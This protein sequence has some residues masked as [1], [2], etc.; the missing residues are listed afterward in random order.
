[1]RGESLGKTIMT[2]RNAR[3][4]GCFASAIS[5]NCSTLT[6]ADAEIAKQQLAATSAMNL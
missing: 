1:M 2:S 3:Y 5:V 6:D 4:S